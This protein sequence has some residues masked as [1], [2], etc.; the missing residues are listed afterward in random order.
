M[1]VTL[2]LTVSKQ[3]LLLLLCRARRVH[4][5]N[6]QTFLPRSDKPSTNHMH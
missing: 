4:S 2:D 3:H 1:A 6:T 5:V